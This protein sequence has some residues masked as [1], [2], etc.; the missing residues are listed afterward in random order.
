MAKHKKRL[1][2]EKQ[3][4]IENLMKKANKNMINFSENEE[5]LKEMTRFMA[6]FHNYST[7]NVSLISAQYDGALAVAGYNKWKEQG[8][9]VRKGQKGIKIFVP[10]SYK[11]YFDEKSQGYIPL[12]QLSN[13]QKNKTNKNPELVTSRTSFFLTSVFDITQTD[14]EPE[15]YPKYYPNKPYNIKHNEELDI[16]Q[17]N[18]YIENIL[19]EKDIN[20]NMNAVI[21]NA[22]KGNYMQYIG[23]E[24]NA[25][26]MIN[27]SD[28]MSIEEKAH[29]LLHE[30]AHSKLHN[31][32]E[33]DI[34][35]KEKAT[36]EIEAEMS[37][38]I[39]GTYYGLDL[40]EISTV[41]LSS[42]K[43]FLDKEKEEELFA[44]YDNVKK[45]SSEM[46]NGIEKQAYL[47]KEHVHS[48]SKEG[49]ETKTDFIKLDSE[50]E[51]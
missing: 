51:L 42:W 26:D 2:E 45:A 14:A 11:V 37:A 35:E 12:K 16:K 48:L 23:K 25:K 27:I 39:V 30:V 21:D 28:R 7:N 20:L 5:G 40:E 3:K 49:K 36:K 4:E 33:V 24:S 6:Q 34:L 43:N 8:L 29:V 1:A 50:L 18:K 46:I 10:S 44:I 32:K 9:N 17:F 41:Y 31:Q 47:E 38:Y 15:D 22:A 19:K 13:E